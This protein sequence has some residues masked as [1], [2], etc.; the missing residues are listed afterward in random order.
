VHVITLE[1][2]T[3]MFPHGIAATVTVT[4]SAAEPPAAR[5][6]PEIV[7]RVPP[8]TGP[9]AGKTE[10]IDGEVGPG[11]GDGVALGS[12]PLAVNVNC[13]PAAVEVTDPPVAVVTI[14]SYAVPATRGE[15]E[16]PGLVVVHVSCVAETR[17][18]GAHAEPSVKLTEIIDPDEPNPEPV[19]VTTVPPVVGPVVGPID[20]TLGAVNA[21]L[22]AA[23]PD[24]P[25]LVVVTDT[26]PETAAGGEPG[27]VHST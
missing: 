27:M 6:A 8:L 14:T 17:V 1:E 24:A 2:T 19:I 26:T 7:I 22:G 23:E 21:K 16:E 18:T 11:P 20:T 15:E 10:S 5:L 12:G 25:P 9:E 13:A 4:T 3:V